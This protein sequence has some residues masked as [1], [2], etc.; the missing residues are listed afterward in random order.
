MRA[1]P[2][3]AALDADQDGKISKAEIENATAALKKLDK[4][5][6]GDLTQEEMRP[7]FA[8]MG[9]RGGPGGGFGGPGGG[10][11][12]PGGPGGRF[13]GPGG[14]GRG[15]EGRGG[16]GRGGDTTAMV[17]RFMQ[18]DKNK[19]GKLSKDEL[20]E[21]MQGIITRADKN[22]DGVATREELQAM[23]SQG[24][25]GDRG[26]RGGF[27]RGGE[28]PGPGGPDF[29]ARMFDERD[30]NKDGKLSADEMPEQMKGR[31]EQIDTDKDGS[32]SREEMESMMSRMRRGGGRD[33]G[34]GRP[35]GG[36][37]PRRR[38]TA[39]T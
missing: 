39:A 8:A 14:E 38:L 2:V 26:G 3:L 29:F 33:V 21:R 1:M 28:G 19:D 16:E 15:G 32:V 35:D 20:S 22:D 25:G 12:G 17:D 24:T 6:D 37:A 13:G 36:G 23:A 7:D 30:A 18:F 9:G 5:N 4:N 11:G 31:L 27:G 10:R 34:R